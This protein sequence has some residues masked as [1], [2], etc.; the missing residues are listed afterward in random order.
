M[1]Y[2][3]NKNGALTGYVFYLE[4]SPPPPANPYN[5]RT[6][7]V[8]VSVDEAYEE[9]VRDDAVLEWLLD[10]VAKVSNIELSCEHAEA[11]VQAGVVKE[12]YIAA[13]WQQKMERI[14][15]RLAEQ[16]LADGYPQEEGY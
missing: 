7:E 5:S 8:P 12:A 2:E 16:K 9:A 14:A 13:Q 6:V 4:K 3:R 11:V 15:E 10:E 1:H